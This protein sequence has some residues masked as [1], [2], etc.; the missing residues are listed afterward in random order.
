MDIA[1]RPVLI[2]IDDGVPVCTPPSRLP[3]AISY[4]SHLG[5]YAQASLTQN[6]HGKEEL[7]LR[8]LNVLPVIDTSAIFSNALFVTVHVLLRDEPIILGNGKSHHGVTANI[9]KLVGELFK[10]NL[11]SNVM[12]VILLGLQADCKV[13]ASKEIKGM[14]MGAFKDSLIGCLEVLHRQLNERY[15]SEGCGIPPVMLGVVGVGFRNM[16][17]WNPLIEKKVKLK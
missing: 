14:T 1:G 17:R 3:V 16:V 2:I 8:R 6:S 7:T 9:V 4:A 10:V 12:G 15:R 5:M 11:E 13:I